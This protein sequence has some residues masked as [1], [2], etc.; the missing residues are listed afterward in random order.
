MNWAVIKVDTVNGLRIGIT[1]MNDIPECEILAT[2]LF[3]RETEQESKRQTEI[4][5][6][7]QFD[8]NIDIY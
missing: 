4:L 1:Q 7:P 6:I 5:N 2:G 8:N 3:E